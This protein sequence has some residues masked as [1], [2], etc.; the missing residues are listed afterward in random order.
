[1]QRVRGFHFCD[2]LCALAT[3][4]DKR[5]CLPGQSGL[6]S[7]GLNISFGLS[8]CFPNLEGAGLVHDLALLPFLP[9]DTLQSPH[10]VHPPGPVYSKT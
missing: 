5:C 6:G 4:R 2:F 3:S 9:Q 7:H 8:H 10:A 1:M